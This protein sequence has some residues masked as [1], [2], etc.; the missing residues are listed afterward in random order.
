MYVLCKCVC[1][2]WLCC[3]ASNSH[4]STCHPQCLSVWG[5]IYSWLQGISFELRIISVILI[6]FY[7]GY[8]SCGCNPT[9]ISALLG[10]L[11]YSNAGRFSLGFSLVL[12]IYIFSTHTSQIVVK[13]QERER[14][15]REERAFDFFVNHFFIFPNAMYETIYPKLMSNSV[16]PSLRNE[17]HMPWTNNTPVS[18][19]TASNWIW[20]TIPVPRVVS[21]CCCCWHK[22]I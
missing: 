14:E 8:R 21:R 3:F 12:Y 4:I 19:C 10:E 5:C 17:M 1:V 18:N 6:T 15:D 9:L 20:H 22:Y 13:T 2:V 11:E 16:C 7:H